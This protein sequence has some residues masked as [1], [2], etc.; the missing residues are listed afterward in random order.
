MTMGNLQS[1][2]LSGNL[3]MDKGVMNA[4]AELHGLRSFHLRD[5]CSDYGSVFPLSR[6]SELKSLTLKYPTA[7]RIDRGAA[8]IGL[9][10]LTSLTQLG[11]FNLL[12]LEGEDLAN[13]TSLEEL[14]LTDCRF[15]D[16]SNMAGFS[17]LR[18][19]RVLKFGKCDRF[20]D[21]VLHSLKWMVHLEQLYISAC[22]SFTGKYFGVLSD[23]QELSTI[24]VQ[25]SSGFQD[26]ALKQLNSITSLRRLEVVMCPLITEDG[27]RVLLNGE[28][29]NLEYL[30]LSAVHDSKL[31]TQ[32][33]QN[34]LPKFK[35]LFR[36]SVNLSMLK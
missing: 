3:L 16:S 23:L 33:F 14:H 28:L 20:D 4:V 25:F 10:A 12:P 1:L 7:H 9:S 18:S 22:S 19:L 15:L 21:A 32:S 36:G 31:T 11:L 30:N 34:K 5:T 35:R 17:N 13:L 2:Y 29:K 8:Q 6:I 27:I 26:N 24:V